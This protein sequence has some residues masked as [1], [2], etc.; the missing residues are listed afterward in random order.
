M[1]HYVQVGRYGIE[2]VTE[3]VEQIAW[4]NCGSISLLPPEIDGCTCPLESFNVIGPLAGQGPDDVVIV[5]KIERSYLY[6]APIHDFERLACWSG[7]RSAVDG[8]NRHR[9]RRVTI[10]TA[11][12]F[13]PVA[14]GDQVK[15]S[16]AAEIDQ[17]KLPA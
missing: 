2:G 12:E 7:E 15:P 9:A 1:D 6:S 14:V 3:S 4:N 10:D 13:E 16:G 11:A 8:V 5:V 17:G